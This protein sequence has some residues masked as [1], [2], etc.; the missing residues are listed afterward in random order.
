MVSYG[1]HDGCFTPN[2]HFGAFAQ[3][4]HFDGHID[5]GSPFSMVHFAVTTLTHGFQKRQFGKAELAIREPIILWHVCRQFG[6]V[7][8]FAVAVRHTHNDEIGCHC[9]SNHHYNNHDNHDNNN[10]DKDDNHTKYQ[11][12]ET[13]KQTTST[14]DEQQQQ[15]TT[16]KTTRKPSNQCSIG[17]AGGW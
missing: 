16:T 17:S 3:I 8:W 7:E 11:D 9:H 1:R 5:I 15:Q 10:N 6:P 2:T 14:D 4:E 13:T 12:Q